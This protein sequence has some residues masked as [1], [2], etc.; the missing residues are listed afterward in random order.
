MR[1][2]AAIAMLALREA[3]RNRTFGVLLLFAVLLLAATPLF[4]SLSLDARVMVV[5][6]VGLA[7]VTLFLHLI[8]VVL[9]VELPAGDLARGTAQ[10]H[11][12]RGTSRGEWVAGLAAGLAALLA[13][14]AAGM[15]ALFALFLALQGLAPALDLPL[16]V[17]VIYGESLLLAGFAF[18]VGSLF[19]RFPAIFVACGFYALGHMGEGFRLSIGMQA[20]RVEALLTETAWFLMPHLEFFGVGP[21]LD[22]TPP[23]TA[24]SAA[25]ILLYAVTYAVA[26]VALSAILFRRKDL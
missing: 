4:S 21:R 14:L 7:A 25:G 1:R 3:V 10:L 24:A 23:L 20:G 11:F 18:L 13:L 6:D 16:A 17:A 19:T 8:A 9:A 26:C 12:A 15:G 22:W 5:T 2:V